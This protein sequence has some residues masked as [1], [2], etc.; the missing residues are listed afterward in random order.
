MREV[1]RHSS[2]HHITLVEIDQQVIN[3]CQQFF[4]ESTATC[5]QDPR[6]TVVNLD[7]ADFVEQQQ[8]NWDIIIADT[9]DP[10]GPAES[11]FR[12]IFY[13]NMYKALSQGGIICCQAECL[14][15]HLDLIC[16]LIDCCSDIFDRAEYASTMIPTYPCGQI[17]F[18]LARKG[19]NQSLRIPI[20]Q[21]SFLDDLQ[22]YSPAQHTAAFTLPP[23]VARKLS[24][25][26]KEE[27]SE[28][29][30]YKCLLEH[31]PIPNCTL[32]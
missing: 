24:Y 25:Y 32:L 26:D 30:E 2:V 7:A 9:S 31:S 16:D 23:F 15:I 20:R 17:G 8:G 6:L 29:D 22:W 28:T 14:W 27:N 4:A 13:D 21:P 11:L 5:F 19:S 12:P 3:V 1:C 10:V 18:V